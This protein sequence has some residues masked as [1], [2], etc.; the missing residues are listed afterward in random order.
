MTAP[1]ARFWIYHHGPVKLTLR[2]GAPSLSHAEGGP[3]DEGWS[4]SGATY[5]LDGDIVYREWWDD[6]SDCDG[7]LSHSGRNTCH[8]S[9]LAALHAGTCR[10]CHNTRTYLEPDC[11]R[12]RFCPWCLG[13]IDWTE[14]YPDWAVEEQSQRDYQA[15]AAGY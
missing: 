6:G 13:V 8:V 14:R 2:D 3:T 12:P 9:R 4:A 5:W 7:R 10:K 11:H 1:N 15:E